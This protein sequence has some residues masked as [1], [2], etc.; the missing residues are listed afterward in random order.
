LGRLGV[1]AAFLE[2]NFNLGSYCG[3]TPNRLLPAV[4]NQ[5]LWGYTPTSQKLTV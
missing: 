4:L 3:I 2:Q 1:C 5:K